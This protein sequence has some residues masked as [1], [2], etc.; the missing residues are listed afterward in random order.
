MNDL[1]T[2]GGLARSVTVKLDK[3]DNYE[4]EARER[5]DDATTARRKAANMRISAGKDLVEAQ[6][7]VQLQRLGWETW[8]E[9]HVPRHKRVIR[10]LMKM[11]KA[12][13]PEDEERRQREADTLRKHTPEMRN[14]TENEYVRPILHEPAVDSDS[15]AAI[16]H[17]WRLLSLND[18]GAFER[19]I[20]DN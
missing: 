19:W 4:A 13:D 2:L 12:P 7:L 18:R 1:V 17:Q 11:A 6:R 8:C 16:K 15:L 10:R 14:R 5:S 3:A 20:K 9:E